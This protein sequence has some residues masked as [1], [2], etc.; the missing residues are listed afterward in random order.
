MRGKVKCG[1]LCVIS[2]L[3]SRSKYNIWRWIGDGLAEYESIRA[4]PEICEEKVNIRLK[5][6]LNDTLQG[7]NPWKWEEG[8]GEISGY[9]YSLAIFL[10]ME[11]EV[12]SRGINRFLK[13]YLESEDFSRKRIE[14]ILKSV[15]FENVYISRDEA[16]KY[17]KESCE[18]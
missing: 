1:C 16:L 9:A 13:E 12:G 14:K 8:T 4:L 6:I 10:K 15:G 18:M 3:I 2:F 17:L 11:K 5:D 7:F